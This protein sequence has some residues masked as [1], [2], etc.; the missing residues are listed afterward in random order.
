MLQGQL[1]KGQAGKHKQMG[2]VQILRSL[3]TPAQTKQPGCMPCVTLRA[4]KRSLLD[5]AGHMMMP[6]RLA[7]LEC[8][9]QCWFFG[10]FSTEMQT[11]SAQ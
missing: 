5:V 7:K 9:W 1:C 4:G 3:L 8:G 6:A 10:C 2:Q 11:L